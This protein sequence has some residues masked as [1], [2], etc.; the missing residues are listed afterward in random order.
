VEK[1]KIYPYDSDVVDDVY[2]IFSNLMLGKNSQYSLE[3]TQSDLKSA[4]KE[5]FVDFMGDKHKVSIDNSIDSMNI[6][7]AFSITGDFSIEE[8]LKNMRDSFLSRQYGD[9]LSFEV[10]QYM[11]SAI[12]QNPQRD[13]ILDCKQA[14]PL[15]FNLLMKIFGITEQELL[16]NEEMR[17]NVTLKIIAFV[18]KNKNQFSQDVVVNQDCQFLQSYVDSYK[19][20]TIED[21]FDRLN[22]DSEQI[23]DFLLQDSS[24]LLQEFLLSDPILKKQEKML[25]PEIYEKVKFLT[26]QSLD[27]VFTDALHMPQTSNI[28]LSIMGAN[29]GAIIH[30]T[31]HFVDNCGFERLCRDRRPPVDGKNESHRMYE[32]LNEAYTEK[33]AQLMMQQRKSKGKG[34]IVRET[35]GITTYEKMFAPLEEAGL[36]DPRL[37][38]SIIDARMSQDPIES[39]SGIIGGREAFDQLAEAIDD[40]YSL[41]T[42]RN[43]IEL[44]SITTGQNQ[45]VSSFKNNITGFIEKFKDMLHNAKMPHLTSLI[46]GVFAPKKISE[47]A[48]HI[49][50][51]DDFVMTKE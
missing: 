45:D 27:N 30:E 46:K 44:V 22:L 24:G 40:V 50:M 26:S 15:N 10:I 9:N 14:F 47:R 41:G 31:L 39:Y 6:I 11:A 4:L 42:T 35:T 34:N 8:Y 21:Y 29:D 28:I 36:F 32:M 49:E 43:L 3:Q 51:E 37:M 2:R 33:F 1:N 18:E 16:Q 23:S 19:E 25:S 17:K 13:V 20:F 5:T 7:P 12:S 38:Q 48:K